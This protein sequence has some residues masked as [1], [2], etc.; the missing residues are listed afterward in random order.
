MKATEFNN[1]VVTE[2]ISEYQRKMPKCAVDA[3]PLLEPV[4]AKLAVLYPLWTFRGNGHLSMNNDRVWLTNFTVLCDGE[5]LGTIE[6]RYEARDYQICVTNERIK[7]KMERTDYYKT[8]DATKAIAKIKKMFGPKD[9]QELAGVSREEAAKI[10]QNAEWNK[11]REIND[12]DEIVQRAARKYVMGVGFDTF[13]A[14][15]KDHYPAQEHDL[16]VT[17]REAA[18]RATEDMKTIS[19]V[20]AVIQ[21][22]ANG[23]VVTRRGGTYVVEHKDKVEICDD[24][25]LPE[26][27]RSRIG[28]LKLI[29]PTQFVSDLGMKAGTNTFVIIEP[30][31]TNVTEGETK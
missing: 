30:D 31:L 26:W 27:I 19:K 8:K 13:M 5:Q 12:A 10:A 20:R 18:T 16:L 17:K 3:H 28:M 6:R 14:Y 9:A 22:Q 1:V 11:Q 15:A 24:N 4:I 23:A 25:T 21:Q 2:E 29:E 7:A